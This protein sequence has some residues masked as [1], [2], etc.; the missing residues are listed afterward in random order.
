MGPLKAAVAR[1]H[2]DKPIPNKQPSKAPAAVTSCHRRYVF[3]SSSD[4]D[5]SAGLA[6]TIAWYQTRQDWIREIKDASYLSYYDRMYT[7]R[8]ETLSRL[9][10]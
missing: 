1:R 6:D 5:F 10:P 3:Q 9:N 7:R 2:E 4:V 8:D